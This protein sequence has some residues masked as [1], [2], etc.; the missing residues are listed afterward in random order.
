M[1]VRDIRG[2]SVLGFRQRSFYAANRACGLA[3]ELT[4][5]FQRE[6]RAIA[7]G[8]LSSVFGTAFQTKRDHVR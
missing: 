8:A 1:V 5:S 3:N 7:V 6:R 4:G 2:N